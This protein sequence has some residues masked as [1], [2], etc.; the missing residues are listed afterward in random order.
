MYQSQLF[1]GCVLVPPLMN[2]SPPAPANHNNVGFDAVET[3]KSQPQT[4]T[5]LAPLLWRV[6]NTRPLVRK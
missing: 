4:T 5:A 3:Q 6:T 2:C 1:G